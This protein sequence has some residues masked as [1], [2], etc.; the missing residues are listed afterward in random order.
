MK[1][2]SFDLETTSLKANFGVVLCAC[3][4]PFGGAVKTFRGDKYSSWKKQRSNDKDLCMAVLDELK[5]YDIWIAH[6]GVKF[7]VPFLTTRLLQHGIVTPKEKIID[8]VKLA[9]RHLRIGYNSLEQLSSFFQ[10]GSKT[11]VDGKYWVRAALDGDRESMDYI[12]EHCIKDVV[13]LEKLMNKLRPYVAK[14]DNWGSD[15]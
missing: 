2:A 5:D 14:I 9:R 4:K 8:P 13:L 3:I 12:V 1:V 6:N 7:D 11:G 15:K 10:L